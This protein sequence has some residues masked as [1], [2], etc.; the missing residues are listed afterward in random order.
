MSWKYILN[1]QEGLL[2][3]L[4]NLELIIY[5]IIAVIAAVIVAVWIIK[6]AML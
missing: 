6:Q 1:F 3:A 4:A 2:Q 5:R